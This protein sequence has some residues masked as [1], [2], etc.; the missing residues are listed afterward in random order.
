PRA[1][2][3]GLLEQPADLVAAEDLRQT[4]PRS[5]GAQLGG[6]IAVEDLLAAQV[7]VEGAQAG[8]LALERRRRRGGPP[9]ASGRELR[10][11]LHQVDAL[12]LE[13]VQLVAL[14]ELGELVEV[15]AVGLER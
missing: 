6:R 12:Y 5:G 7:S 1:R 4:G 13:R 10:D 11:E 14:E 15:R 9:G 8:D 2:P 3:R